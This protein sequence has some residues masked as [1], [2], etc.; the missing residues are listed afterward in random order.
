MLT[1]L[2]NFKNL[3]QNYGRVDAI[4]IFWKENA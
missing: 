3:S 1:H 4:Q 2:L